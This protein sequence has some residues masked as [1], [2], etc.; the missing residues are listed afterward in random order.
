MLSKK[1][2]IPILAVAA[3]ISIGAGYMH[4]SNTT[5][6]FTDAEAT[7][8]TMS[9]GHDT[10]EIVETFTPP[11]EVPKNTETTYTKDVAVRNDGTVPCYVRVFL[12]FSDQLARDGSKVSADGTNYYSMADFASHLPSGWTY[13]STGDLSGYYYYT[14]A[15]KTG[16]ST[17]SLIKSVKTTLGSY[18]AQNDF[19]I[20][21]HEESVQAGNPDGSG[22][23]A[24]D[25]AWKAFL[26]R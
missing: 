17:S 20:I 14:T 8:N 26:N 5:A 25:A 7:V 19:D 3:A 10:T 18:A 6:Y 13:V 1:K 12:D 11:N 2:Y 15:L 22:A 23:M 4:I 16:E 24:Y 9:V 21:V